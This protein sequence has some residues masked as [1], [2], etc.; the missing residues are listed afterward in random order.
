MEK[1]WWHIPTE[2]WPQ[3]SYSWAEEEL[4]A[5]LDMIGSPMPICTPCATA[6]GAQHLCTN[7]ETCPCQHRTTVR[8]EDG[9]LSPTSERN[10][11]LS[12]QAIE[13]NETTIKL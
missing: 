6:D 12:V 4:L 10:K 11:L 5:I 2:G 1:H 7:I 9:T 8:Q 13:T 3:S